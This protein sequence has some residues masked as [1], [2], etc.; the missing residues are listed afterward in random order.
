M[1]WCSIGG[2]S[3]FESCIDMVV[4]LHGMAIDIK[5]GVRFGLID[6]EH[7]DIPVLLPCWWF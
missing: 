1:L 5:I 2:L 7:F 6:D 3:R 4:C